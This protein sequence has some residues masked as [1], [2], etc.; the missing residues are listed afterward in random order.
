MML[1][2]PLARMAYKQ[3]IAGKAAHSHFVRNIFLIT[4]KPLLYALSKRLP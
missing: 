1:N 3:N 2:L 4:T